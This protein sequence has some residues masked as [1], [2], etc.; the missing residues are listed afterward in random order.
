MKLYT[1]TLGWNAEND[2]NLRRERKM[3]SEGEDVTF[4]GRLFQMVAPATGNA[5]SPTVDS[6]LLG[7]MRLS[8]NAERRQ[9]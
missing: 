5:R 4:A 1:T 3:P 9:R 2:R 6:R 7:T 8:E